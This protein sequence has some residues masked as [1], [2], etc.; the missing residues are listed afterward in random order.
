[1]KEH[2]PFYVKAIDT[3]KAVGPQLMPVT[4]ALYDAYVEML[5]DLDQLSNRPAEVEETK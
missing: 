1:M 5:S 3:I 2:D 4:A